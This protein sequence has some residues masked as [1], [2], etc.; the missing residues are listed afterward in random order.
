MRGGARPT[1]GWRIVLHRGRTALLLLS[2]GLAVQAPVQLSAAILTDQE[3]STSSLTAASSFDL[4]APTVTAGVV[5][6]AGESVV[7]RIHAGGAYHVYANA[8][9][10]GAWASGVASVSADA[11]NVTAGQSAVPLVAGAYTV[12]GVSYAYRSAA[13]A[14]DAGLPAGDRVVSVTATDLDGNVGD[15]GVFSVTVD[16]TRP[17][18]AAIQS[19][20]GGGSVGKPEAGDSITFSFTEPIDPASILVGWTGG[21]TPVVVR[22]A[23]GGLGAD[24]LTVRDAGNVA[25]LPL[26]TVGLGGGSYVSAT[27][28]FGTG[29]ATSTMSMSGS[30]VSIVLGTPSGTTGTAPLGANM[31]WT[32]S[33]AAFDGAGNF[34]ES[35][36]VTENDGILPDVE[37]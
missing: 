3:S 2:V 36:A 10:S 13:M 22:I 4:V 14:A 19:A 11:S 15:P 16:N 8:I 18:G 21:P 23:D 24:I 33:T 27:R 25:Q 6:K 34:C 17:A 28:T 26:G 7:G 1:V 9:D 5:S 30:T 20:N 32:P 31:S 37:F 29:G 35:T 12:G